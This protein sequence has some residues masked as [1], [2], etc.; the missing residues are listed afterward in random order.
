M[1]EQAAAW[2]GIAAIVRLAL[3]I[4][5]CPPAQVMTLPLCGDGSHRI[6]IP[7]DPKKAPRDESP[8]GCHALCGRKLAGD[9][10]DCPD[11]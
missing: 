7:L 5:C 3:A 11:C 4:A 1:T 8:T 9:G 2:I 6:A 10:D